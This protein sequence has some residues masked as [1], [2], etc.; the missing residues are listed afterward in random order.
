[1]VAQNQCPEQYLTVLVLSFLE[2]SCFLEL[3]TAN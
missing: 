2:L 3:S 1:M